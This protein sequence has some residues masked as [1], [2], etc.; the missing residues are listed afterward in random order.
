M[1]FNKE[2]LQKLLKEKGVKSQED[3]QSLLRELTKEVIEAVYD[4]ELTGRLGYT[5]HEQNG[6][7]DGNARNGCGKK[8]VN[9]Y[10]GEIELEPP[11]DRNSRYNPKIVKKRQKDITGIETKV[12]SIYAKGMSNQDISSHIYEIYGIEL[13]DESIS[14]VTN[15]VIE[16]AMKWQSRPPGSDLLHLVYGR[17]GGQ[18]EERRSCQECNRVRHSWDRP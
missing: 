18:A 16:R 2:E 17:H 11:R 10:F 15:T 6:S 14:N 9:S 1:F 7:E 4:G 3:M 13:P 5:K 12:T 8:K